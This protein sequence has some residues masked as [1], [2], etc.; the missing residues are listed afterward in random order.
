LSSSP[1]DTLE[2]TLYAETDNNNKDD[3]ASDTNHSSRICE[4]STDSTENSPAVSQTKQLDDN[5]LLDNTTDS[6]T[7]SDEL[8]DRYFK[9][10]RRRTSSRNSFSQESPLL[11]AVA[12]TETNTTDETKSER[13]KEEQLEQNPSILPSAPSLLTQKDE[14]KSEHI[15]QQIPQ[16]LEDQSALEKAENYETIINDNK[17][18]EQKDEKSVIRYRPRRIRQRLLRN[19]DHATAAAL[20]ASEANVKGTSE[21]SYI[22]L[23]ADQDNQLPLP[24]TNTSPSHLEETTNDS[25]NN[26]N[27]PEQQQHQS[28]PLN[29]NH[30]DEYASNNT[31]SATLPRGGLKRHQISSSL[32]K[33]VHFADSLGLDLAQIKYIRSSVTSDIL[34]DMIPDQEL[35]PWD[36]D[37]TV[38]PNHRAYSSPPSTVHH[39]PKTRRYFCLFRQPS[40]EPPDSYLHEIWRAQIKLEYAEIK[41]KQ[42]EQPHI[43][44]NLSR[45][46][47]H[48]HTTD[49]LQQQLNG[50]LWVTNIDFWKYVSIKYTFN[51][52]INTYEKE[53]T[54]MYHS[55]DYRNIDKY[56]FIVDIPNDID[57]IDFILR[58]TSGGQEHYDNNYGN[59]YTFEADQTVPI[60]ISLPHDCDFNEMRFY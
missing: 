54:H 50:T 24:H 48:H 20:A 31:Q 4:A 9:R 6:V 13:Q 55:Q 40:S 16:Q 15:Q 18:A 29:D 14:I 41:V 58:Y 21:S 1:V 33:N 59:N 5:I 28:S 42:I 32:K 12:S 49:T 60:T 17:N 30:I 52:W 53:A 3:N 43:N 35:K 37:L 51:R 56:E 25:A 47:F 11:P 36:F 38:S 34:D 23:T 8:Q 10:R 46:I 39:Q 2:N 22:I 27:D 7:N 44:D 19:Y 57:R 26:N 45:F